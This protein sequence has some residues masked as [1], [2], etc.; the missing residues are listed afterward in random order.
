MVSGFIENKPHLITK[1]PWNGS[2]FHGF[3]SVREAMTDV[4][5]VKKSGFVLFK[6][7]KAAQ[8]KAITMN[9]LAS[10]AIYKQMCFFY[11]IYIAFAKS[12]YDPIS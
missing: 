1:K 7:I 10:S 9:Y 8:I 5:Y 6:I 11:D 12:W 3:L 2:P 4:Q